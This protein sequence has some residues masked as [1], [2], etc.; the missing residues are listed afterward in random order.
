MVGRRYL[1]RASTKKGG[2]ELREGTANLP[3]ERLNIMQPLAKALQDLGYGEPT[4]IQTNVIPVALKGFHIL[5]SAYAG[6]GKTDAYALPMMHRL[7]LLLAQERNEGQSRPPCAPLALVV[8]PT[9][10]LA[11]QTADHLQYLAGYL[12]SAP[13]V[14]VAYGKS[15]EGFQKQARLLSKGVDI[16]VGTP[17]RLCRLLGKSGQ[18]GEDGTTENPVLDLT[19]TATTVMDECDLLLDF[20][21]LP[22]IF[23][24]YQ[25]LPKPNK[26]KSVIQM[27]K[28]G[29]PRLNTMQIMLLSATL[30]PEMEKAQ[31]RIASR[32]RIFDLNK[33][34]SLPPAV[35]AFGYEV[36]NVNKIELLHYLFRRR[37][38]LKGKRA[39]VFGRTLGKMV[40]VAA[41]LRGIG[42]TAGVVGK[43]RTD[44][45]NMDTVEEFRTG[46]MQVICCTDLLARGLDIKDI[47]A[48]VNFDVPHDPTDF[49]HRTGRT[50]RMKR[51][52]LV[53]TLV[54]KDPQMVKTNGQWVDLNE[55]HF[56]QA[57]RR[58]CKGAMPISTIPGPWQER[59]LD[60]DRYMEKYRSI[61]ER[62]AGELRDKKLDQFRRRSSKIAD[63]PMNT[64]RK[65]KRHLEDPESTPAVRS[66]REGRYESVVKNVAR[67]HALKD[68]SIERIFQVSKR[69]RK[70]QHEKDDF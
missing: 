28:S 34:M 10:A 13:R 44:R 56:Y 30:I 40:Q 32:V 51:G 3:F 55:Q 26:R 47:T 16:V 15:P 63:L 53:I 59:E 67:R 11:T 5:A 39:I 64:R 23:S 20:R 60:M 49:L 4:A 1:G 69:K 24:I 6:S 27:G 22:Q 50:G 61:H 65:T 70:H 48:V 31:R 18:P 19:Y 33:A 66:F 38:S 25:S 9:T 45:Q 14:V 7:H 57:I 62:V 58:V 12:P 54:S 37:G 2:L 35:K 17:G 41:S 21:M 43:D 29:P 68:R 46:S 42:I 36:H 52:G 8:V